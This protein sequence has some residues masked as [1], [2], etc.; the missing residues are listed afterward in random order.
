METPIYPHPRSIA[1]TTGPCVILDIDGVIYNFS[2]EFDQYATDLGWD[3]S[4]GHHK[5]NFFE[6]Y[7]HPEHPDG[8]PLH[9]FLRIY[10]EGYREGAILHQYPPMDNLTAIPDL[11]R[12]NSCC[13][14]HWVTHRDIVDVHDDDIFE[15]TVRWFEKWQIP[16]DSLTI[17]AEKGNAAAQ[18]ASGQ[19][20]LGAIE[21]KPANLFDIV[22]ATG[23]TG[24]L[25][26]RPYNVDN[27]TRMRMLHDNRLRR[28][29]NLGRFCE[30]MHD[31]AVHTRAS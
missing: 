11:H 2:D 12:L 20:V 27:P 14:L 23:C 26:D 24:F 7:R 16:W 21:D 15:T 13:D 4:A 29:P 9:E 6:D 22:E 1:P 3:V 5:W 8:M 30:I 18:I 31:I 10:S 19:P 17:T 25:V 28:I